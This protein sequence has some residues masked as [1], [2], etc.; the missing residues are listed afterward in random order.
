MEEEVVPDQKGHIP[1]CPWLEGAGSTKR[2]PPPEATGQ[3]PSSTRS[4]MLS[5]GPW[6]PWEVTGPGK[7]GRGEWAEARCGQSPPGGEWKGLLYPRPLSLRRREGWRMSQ[8]IQSHGVF[9]CIALEGRALRGQLLSY[10][11]VK[12]LPLS[13]YS[14]QGWWQGPHSGAEVQSS[15]MGASRHSS[16][17]QKPG[18]ESLMP[19][20][21][22]VQVPSLGVLRRWEEGGS[23]GLFSPHPQRRLGFLGRGVLLIWVPISGYLSCHGL[24]VNSPS[25]VMGHPPPWWMTG[26]GPAGVRV[27]GSRQGPQ[28]HSS[29]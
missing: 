29:H 16:E 6:A 17:E 18:K 10:S 24:L 25:L 8:G 27:G 20:L 4:C 3:A 21:E 19:H 28:L 22:R 11:A 1:P 13:Q 26:V 12:C 2:P 23:S 5:R 7:A 9:M 14:P 15:P